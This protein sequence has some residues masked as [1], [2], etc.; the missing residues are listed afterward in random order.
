MCRRSSTTRQRLQSNGLPLLLVPPGRIVS[1]Q[2]R[3][4]L[5]ATKLDPHAVV[6][7]AWG[8]GDEAVDEPMVVFDP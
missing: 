4:S 1:A 3:S 2:H 6:A 7:R 5:K 8:R